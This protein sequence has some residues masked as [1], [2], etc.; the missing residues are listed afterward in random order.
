MTGRDSGQPV[1]SRPLL[2][3]LNQILRGWPGICPAVPD[4]G[5][6]ASYPLPMPTAASPSSNP[7]TAVT[8]AA[9][10]I[11]SHLVE[12]LL[13]RG[14]RVR[15]LVHYNALR[16]RGHLEQVIAT[17]P[18][19]DCLETVFGDVQ[20]A[21]CLREFVE[22]ADVVCHLAALIGIPY[23]YA[24]PQSYVNV[25]VLGTLNLLEACRDAKTPRVI[26]TSTSEA[27]GTAARTPQDESHPL[28]AQSPY[29]ATKIGGDKLAEAYHTSFDLPV[30]ILRPFNTYGP[31]QSARAIVPAIITQALSPEC[32]EIRLG[33]LDPVRDLTY[34]DDTARAFLN[35][36]EAPLAV[37]AG[38]LFHLGTGEGVSIGDLARMIL[39]V[40]G[41]EK[42]V[43]QVGERIRPEKSEVRVLLSDNRLIR[44][45][46]GWQPE[47][48]LREGIRRT[49]D[50]INLHA[51]QYRPDEYAV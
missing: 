35:V 28:Q 7:L 40:A 21:R 6:P 16:S 48:S 15:A 9:G 3:N 10:F 43:V 20:D 14:D 24:A 36:A 8:G 39:E 42:P 38:R 33:A 22:G 41:I 5:Y 11:G 32:P 27:L 37:V 44:D 45:Q 51:D 29:S 12:A 46:V 1:P 17:H 2:F 34:V 31:R 18:R 47:T 50:W 13:S 26:H 49:I 23:S 30:T 4:P 19:S 25:N